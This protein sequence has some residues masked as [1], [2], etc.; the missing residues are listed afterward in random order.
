MS[1]IHRHL[2][3][4]DW[5]LAVVGGLA[6]ASS[7]GAACRDKSIHL[8][9]IQCQSMFYGSWQHNYYCQHRQEDRANKHSISLDVYGDILS[10]L[11]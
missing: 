3:E 6:A 8:P 9:R 5:A 4:I 11:K 1:D 10:I 7:N 2:R